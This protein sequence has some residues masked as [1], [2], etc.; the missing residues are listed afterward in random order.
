[1]FEDRAYSEERKFYS[2]VGGAIFIFSLFIISAILIINGS[3]MI[4]NGCYIKTDICGIG[5]IISCNLTNCT[6]LYYCQNNNTNIYFNN[7]F[8]D[9]DLNKYYLSDL[10]GKS[11]LTSGLFISI[12]VFAFTIYF[13]QIKF[14]T[15]DPL[16]YVKSVFIKSAFPLFGFCLWLTFILI[17]FTT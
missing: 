10:I 7:G 13:V 3:Y 5:Q 2:I 14:I 11:M 6:N 8:C 15:N 17:Y 1:M 12:F 4:R 9:L 16:V